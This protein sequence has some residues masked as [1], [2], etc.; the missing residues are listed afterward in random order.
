MQERLPLHRPDLTV[1]EEPAE[2]QVAEAPA[3]SVGVMVGTAEE[4]LAT[5]EAREQ[6]GT[7]GSCGRTREQRVEIFGRSARVAQMGL[8][9]HAR[10]QQRPD[11]EAPALPIDAEH[12]ADAEVAVPGRFL[13]P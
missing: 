4:V 8:H 12:A 3:R 13:L 11:R 6:Q 7:G 2:R 1:A 5:A 10:A 9:D